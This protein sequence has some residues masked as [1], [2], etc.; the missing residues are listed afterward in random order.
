MIDMWRALEGQLL[1]RVAGRFPRVET[2][3]RLARFLRGM[4]A[5]PPRKDLLEHRRVRR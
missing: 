2:R 3:Q 4:V 1:D 5:E